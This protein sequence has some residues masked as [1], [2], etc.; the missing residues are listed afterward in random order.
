MEE[1]I[2]NRMELQRLKKDLW[3]HR[4]PGTKATPSVGS[5]KGECRKLREKFEK[6]LEAKKKI[7]QE[8][9][10]AKERK[11]KMDK[12]IEEMKMRKKMEEIKRLEEKEASR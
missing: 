8:E 9:G 4:D 2:K 10:E 3:K 7:L 5:G 11:R 6:V 12:Q 1:I